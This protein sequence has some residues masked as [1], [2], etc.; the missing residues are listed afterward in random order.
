MRFWSAS[1]LVGIGIAVYTLDSGIR[2]ESALGLLRVASRFPE[3][4]SF[5]LDELRQQLNQDNG[6]GQ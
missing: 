1:L 6:A 5:A 2:A 3:S 4:T